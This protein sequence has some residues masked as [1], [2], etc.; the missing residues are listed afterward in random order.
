M[1]CFPPSLMAL[2]PPPEG[3]APPSP[4]R[5]PLAHTGG[6]LTD[7]DLLAVG[8][9]EELGGEQQLDEGVLQ[10]ADQE[11]APPAQE[12]HT[13]AGMQGES[14]LAR[15]SPRAPGAI[16]CDWEGMRK[17]HRRLPLDLSGPPPC[18]VQAGGRPALMHAC[19]DTTHLAR[20]EKTF[21]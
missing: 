8:L 17:C 3:S 18:K 21:T 5:R 10:A 19:G 1:F 13:H 20:V 14:A 16:T 7:S 11:R 9:V 15:S 6:S 4:S 12:G 2:H